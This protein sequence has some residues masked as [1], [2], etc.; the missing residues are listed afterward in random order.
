M[1]TKGLQES[2]QFL[3]RL[4]YSVNVYDVLESIKIIVFYRQIGVE[5]ING[6]LAS[7]WTLANHPEKVVR[8]AI[9]NS[10]IT[11]YLQAPPDEIAK[12]LIS[13]IYSDPQLYV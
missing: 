11:L 8:E 7:L 2:I 10:F 4:I 1:V 5:N 13:L 6:L 12:S 9:I 3:K